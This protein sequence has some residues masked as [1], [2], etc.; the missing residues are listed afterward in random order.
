MGALVAIYIADRSGGPMRSVDTA[1]FVAG[2]GIVGD[3]YFSGTGKW[4]PAVQIPKFEVTLIEAEQVAH[5]NSTYGAAMCPEQLRRNLVTSGIALNELVGAEFTVGDVVLK[6]IK[7][8]EPCEYIVGLTLP[9]VLVG[10]AHRAGLRA[11]IVHG[12]VVNLRDG[13]TVRRVA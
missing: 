10:L 3:R 4:S 1:E 8:C 5:F 2:K 11:G 6:G 7:L 9:N 12:G 13:I